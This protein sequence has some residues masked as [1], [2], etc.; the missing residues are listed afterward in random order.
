MLKFNFLEKSLGLVSPPHF[1]Y[2]FSR[3]MFLMLHSIHWPNFI[4]QI[5]SLTSRD[6]GEYVY[7]NCLLNI[8]LSFAKNCLRHESASFRN[9]QGE[10]HTLLQNQIMRLPAW[11]ITGNIWLRREFQKGLQTLSIHQEERVLTQIIVRPRI[12]GLTG[13]ING[14]LIHFN[15][16]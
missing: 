9:P 3:K 2:D 4:D 1:A 7:Y 11:I 6:I 15:V 13:V 5:S 12:S 8:W 16:F 10:T 14:K